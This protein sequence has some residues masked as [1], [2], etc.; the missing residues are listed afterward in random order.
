MTNP[1]NGGGVDVFASHRAGRIVRVTWAMAW[2]LVLWWGWPLPGLAKTTISRFCD[3]WADSHSQ[4]QV[5]CWVDGEDWL[6]RFELKSSSTA[7]KSTNSQEEAIVVGLAKDGDSPVYSLE[8]RGLQGQADANWE[9]LLRRPDGEIV[10]RWDTKGVAV[11]K[12]ASADATVAQLRLPLR[13]LEPVFGKKLAAGGLVR[14]AF[15]RSSHVQGREVWSSW[16]FF[17]NREGKPWG[18]S[19]FGWIPLD[20]QPDG[21]FSISQEPPEAKTFRLA[22]NKIRADLHDYL[23]GRSLATT[24]AAWYDQLGQFPEAEAEWLVWEGGAEAISRGATLS[25]APGGWLANPFTICIGLDSRESADEGATIEFRSEADG[26]AGVAIHLPSRGSTSARMV[27]RV[28][29]GQLGAE[30]QEAAVLFPLDR[31]Q[32]PEFISI[33]Y[34]GTGY[35]ADLK[36]LVDGIQVPIQVMQHPAPWEIAAESDFSKAGHEDWIV[37]SHGGRLK[38]LQVYRTGLTAIESMANSPKASLLSWSEWSEQQKELWK[39]HCAERHDRDG[40]YLYE[41][42]VHYSR[43]ALR[44]V[45]EGKASKSRD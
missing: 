34:P 26:I 19:I 30:R 29:S 37:Q 4:T 35:L 16:R 28:P 15:L 6:V 42:L 3:P 38:T 21:D 14:A 10:G 17:A 43:S 22:A 9:G 32:T 11:T 36:L 18:P 20:A 40:G 33:S 2:I 5:E 12:Q 27:M 1:T 44:A 31:V 39:D 41:S 45:T 23:Q 7:S 24:T 25:M 8:I 13:S